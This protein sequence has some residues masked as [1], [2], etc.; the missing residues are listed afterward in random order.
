MQVEGITS[1]SD[2]PANLVSQAS[3]NDESIPVEM[4]NDVQSHRRLRPDRLKRNEGSAG[5]DTVALAT[6]PCSACS[7]NYCLD[8]L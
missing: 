2:H 6:L 8:R 3:M 7:S 5:N 1:D 4:S